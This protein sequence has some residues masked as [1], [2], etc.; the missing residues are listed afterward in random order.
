LKVLITGA[1]GLLGSKLVEAAERLDHEVYASDITQPLQG[2]P[3][4]FDIS[5]RKQVDSNFD[6]VVPEAVVHCAAMTDVDKCET[7]RELAWKINVT[8]TENIVK[9]S[10]RTKAFLI[11]VS[12]DFVFNGEK[13]R[14]TEEDAPDPINYYGLTKLEAEKRVQ[15]MT[16][17]HCIVRA[18]VIFG[19]NPAL[20]KV[21]FALWLLE[22]LRRK[23]SVNI[24]TDQWNSPTL[25]TNMA[26]MMLE[27]LE[28]KLEGA[29]HVSGATRINRFD[30]AKLLASTFKL[31]SDLIRP[32]TS[33]EFSWPARRP[34][35]S[36]LSTK[37]ASRLL[38]N[39]PLEIRQAFLRL[40]QEIDSGFL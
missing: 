17:K 31:D 9:A 16:G 38:R 37:K 19:S 18:S 4:H 14:Y 29:I 7:A 6:K 21:N 27:I 36:S 5:D 39:K 11:C 2:I 28:R 23:E 8:G 34:R 40:K 25:N 24:V 3:V 10:D 32:V 26:E 33:A 15:D 35:D 20:G 1:N 30:F 13:G 22:K 12:T